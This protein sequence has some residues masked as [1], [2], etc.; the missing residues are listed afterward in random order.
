MTL[1]TRFINYSVNR[2]A[3]SAIKKGSLRLILPNGTEVT[4]G[5]S[6]QGPAPGSIAGVRG[7]KSA[8][9][10]SRVKVY[11]CNMLL[12]LA[13]DTDIGLGESYMKGEY[14][15]DDLTNFLNVLVQNIQSCNDSQGKL[16]ILN[17]LGTQVCLTCV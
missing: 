5:D 7:A 1:T 8:P 13:K 16:G 11:D 4:Y 10:H 17:W 3:G 14:E 12:R 9:C 2:M 15:P 6:K